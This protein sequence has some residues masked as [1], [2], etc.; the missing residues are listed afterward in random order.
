MRLLKLTA[1]SA[2]GYGLYR[3]FSGAE[4]PHARVAFAGGEA[5]GADVQ[6]R[7]AG[8]SAI[9]T[10]TPEWSKVDQAVDESFPA[11]DPAAY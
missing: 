8:P 6:V 3:L 4:R 11:S 9:R 5:T 7:N 10:T 1:L 2:L